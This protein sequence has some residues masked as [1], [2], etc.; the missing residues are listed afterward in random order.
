[1]ISNVIIYVSPWTAAVRYAAERET[2]AYAG[3]AD[4][5]LQKGPM[6]KFWES[7]KILLSNPTF[8]LLV[9]AGMKQI[10]NF[11]LKRISSKQAYCDLT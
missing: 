4:V 1:M 11:Y 6:Q 10:S 2:Q 7:T 8:D 5:D 9:L 3:G